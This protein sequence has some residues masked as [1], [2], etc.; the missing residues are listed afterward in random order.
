MTIEK[1]KE[2][3]KHL[4]EVGACSYRKNYWNG[5]ELT[6]DRYADGE[7]LCGRRDIDRAQEDARKMGFNSVGVGHYYRSYF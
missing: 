3:H 7:F 1:F 2:K 6:I 4:F 5:E